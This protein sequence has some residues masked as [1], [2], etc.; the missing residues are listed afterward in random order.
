MKG[1][2]N[3][4]ILHHPCCPLEEAQ[5]REVR[6]GVTV[7]KFEEEGIPIS[8]GLP[9]VVT[10]DKGHCVSELPGPTC[11]WASHSGPPTSQPALTFQVLHQPSASVP[12]P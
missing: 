12:V 6:V 8:Q 10:A 5:K 9:K 4:H 7:R 1:R 2:V 11:L 3:G